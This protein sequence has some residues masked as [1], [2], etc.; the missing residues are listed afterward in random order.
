MRTLQPE[1]TALRR[2]ID[3]CL[4][5]NL[6]IS[7][8]LPCDLFLLQFEFRGRSAIYPPRGNPTLIPRSQ[9]PSAGRTVRFSCLILGV[10]SIFIKKWNCKIKVNLRLQDAMIISEARPD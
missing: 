7:R 3:E 4:G 9:L 8:D 1:S 2:V 10:H 5:G 6:L